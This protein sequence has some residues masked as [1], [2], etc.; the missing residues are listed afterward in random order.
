MTA[1]T[2]VRIASSH[3]ELFAIFRLRYE[4]YV[5]QQGKSLP[6]ADR[7][8]RIVRDHLDDVATNFYVGSDQGEIVACGR[9]TIGVWPQVCDV[10]FSLPAFRGFQREDFYYISKVMLNPR[11]RSRSAIPSIFIAMYRDGRVRNVPFGIAHCN[12]KL[13]PI[14]NRFGWR[15][16]GLEFIDPSAGPQVPILIVAPDIGYLRRR[17]SVLVQTAEEFPADPLYAGWFEKH[18]PEYSEP[19]GESSGQ[20]YERKHDMPTMEEY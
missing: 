6:T 11:F 10:P 9:A 16:F 1:E 15:R 20:K 13:V 8:L 19:K 4:V 18:F 7:T 14:Y 3:E 2:P 5:E 12:P 17:K